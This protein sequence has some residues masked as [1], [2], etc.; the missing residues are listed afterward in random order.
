MK[1]L[2]VSPF[3]PWPLN[4]GVT[5]RMHSILKALQKLGD[6][7]CIFIGGPK[8]SHDI[9]EDVVTSVI[10]ILPTPDFT[11]IP[12]IGRLQEVASACK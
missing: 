1:I 12:V 3:R 4:I 7:D 2:F 8:H 9:P 11:S 6:V 10:H 5:L